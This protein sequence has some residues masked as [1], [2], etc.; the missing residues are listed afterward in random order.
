MLDAS[1]AT[2]KRDQVEQAIAIASGINPQ[3]EPKRFD[4]LR[5]ELKRLLDRDRRQEQETPRGRPVRRAFHGEGP[6]GRGIDVLYSGYE[7]FA[8]LIALRLMR[9]GLTQA[10]A[11]DFL[12]DLRAPLAGFH[13]ET[14]RQDPHDLRPDVD[15]GDLENLIRIG[16]LIREPED[17]AHLT[18]LAGEHAEAFDVSSPEKKPV[19]GNICRSLDDLC[20]R[21]RWASHEGHA[22]IVVELVNAAHQLAHHLKRIEPRPRGRR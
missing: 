17:L 5:I 10:R 14:L 6:P 16:A 20:H 1:Y 13:Y 4:A 7:A 2:F 21:L 19:S 12:R 18:A 15:P 11:V 22:L 3:H 8:L 9:G